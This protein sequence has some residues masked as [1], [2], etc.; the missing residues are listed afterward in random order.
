[1]LF[2]SFGVYLK[3]LLNKKDLDQLLSTAPLPEGSLLEFKDDSIT[4]RDQDRLN[5]CRSDALRFQKAWGIVTSIKKEKV[6][7]ANT[8]TPASAQVVLRL[9]FLDRSENVYRSFFVRTTAFAAAYA[10]RFPRG[11]SCTLSVGDMVSGVLERPSSD[12]NSTAFASWDFA[13]LG[14]FHNYNTNL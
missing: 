6:I 11:T 7:S 9:N 10:P 12:R 2:N 1:M 14:E 3:S 13:Q 5:L 8:T 4:A